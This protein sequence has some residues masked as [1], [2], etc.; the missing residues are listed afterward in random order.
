MKEFLVIIMLFL[1]PSSGYAKEW[2]EG[3]TLHNA[4]ALEWQNATFQNKLAT[5]GDIVSATWQNKRFKPEIQSKITSMD[6]VMVLAKELMTGLDKAFEKEPD[7][8]QNKI[9]YTN[10]KVSSSAAL[11]MVMMGWVKL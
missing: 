4:T 9:M 2:Y 8:K 3:G 1:I 7:P 5:C 10:Q 11:L 6:V